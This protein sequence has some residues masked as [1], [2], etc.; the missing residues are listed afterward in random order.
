[1]ESLGRLRLQAVL[2]LAVVC[3]MGVVGGVAIERLRHERGPHDRRRGEPHERHPR[4]ELPPELSEG[5]DLS[6]EQEAQ[7]QKV[8]ER[9]RP[10]TEALLDQYLPR[11][12]AVTDS[13]R[14]EVRLLLRP[15]QQKIF[16]SRQHPAFDQR[17]PS[18]F[19]RGEPPPRRDRG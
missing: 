19:G 10:Q 17:G 15:E 1:M 8:L 18:T 7:I 9:Y 5:M 11:L 4:S 6:A 2:L 14:A 13:V 12:R 3:A 16:D